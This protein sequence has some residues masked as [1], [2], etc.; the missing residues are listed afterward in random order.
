MDRIAGGLIVELRATTKK[1]V[2]PGPGHEVT[3][4]SPPPDYGAAIRK[5]VQAAQ[6]LKEL[7]WAYT[8]DHPAPK[9]S[10]SVPSDILAIAEGLRA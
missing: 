4:C 7:P 6:R 1:G 2:L 8:S 3:M 10:R 5:R 9:G